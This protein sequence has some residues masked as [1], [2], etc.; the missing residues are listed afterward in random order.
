MKRFLGAAALALA[1]SA[2]VAT[3][4]SCGGVYTVQR[5]DSLSLIADRQYK[6][7][8]TWTE[9]HRNNLSVIG[10]NPNALRVGMEL[11]LGCIDGLPVGLPGGNA[12]V[13]APAIQTASA[14]TP[15]RRKLE[16]SINLV[17]AGDFAP[18]TDQALENEG[19]ITDVVRT[20]MQSS[21]SADNYNVHWV[22]D[23]SS[24]LDPLMTNAMMDMAFPWYKP[25]CAGSPDNYRC[26][27][28]HFSDPMFEMLIL[29][30]VDKTRPIPFA[31]D[32]DIEGRTLCRPAGY[33]THDLDRADR[34]WISDGKITLKR[35]QT[36]KGCFDMLVAGEVDAVAM[37][38]FTGRSAIK[39]LGLKDQVEVVQGRPVSIEGLHVLVHKDHPQ[40][41]ALL[42]TINGGL[43]AIK[44]SGA[45]QQVIDRHMSKIWAEF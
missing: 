18:F 30:F 23:W 17:T 27:N 42:S 33:F 45:Y 29:L 19:L 43:D 28:F 31:Q 7:A 22:N 38:E 39:D 41:D 9:V 16:Q 32:S 20:A 15:S 4:Q 40:A 6:N 21:Q 37:N 3:A 26:T 10:E 2:T 24:H 8:A 13:A 11:R 36:V 44:L 12:T 5:G 1:G 14:A 35:P 25:D 34:R